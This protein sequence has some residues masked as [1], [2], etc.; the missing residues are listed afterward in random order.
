MN[1][2]FCF[3]TV[4]YQL[5]NEK[6]KKIENNDVYFDIP[7][8]NDKY[9]NERVKYIYEDEKIMKN[10]TKNLNKKNFKIY[11]KKLNDSTILLKFE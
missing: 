9:F 8:Y 10:L 1:N 7:Y 11:F 3:S 5:K 6:W 2:L 4:L